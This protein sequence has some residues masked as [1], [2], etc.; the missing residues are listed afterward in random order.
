MAKETFTDNK[1]VKDLIRL[2]ADNDLTEIELVEDKAKIRLKR[3]LAPDGGGT[4]PPPATPSP[5]RPAAAATA[6]AQD[7]NLVPVKSPMVG[8]FYSAANPESD[9][10]VKIGAPVEKDTIVCIIE[11]MKVFNEIRAETTGA[12]VKILV[13]NGQAVEYNQ[14]LFLVKPE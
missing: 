14:P 9:P 8:T 12:I 4:A 6:P 1:R 11:A 13:Q 7:E 2:M 10:Y 5:I 3:D